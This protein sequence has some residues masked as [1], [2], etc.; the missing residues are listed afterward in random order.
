MVTLMDSA[1]FLGAEESLE[2]SVKAEPAAATAHSSIPD[3]SDWLIVSAAEAAGEDEGA[4]SPQAPPPQAPV[5][6]LV[7]Q[8]VAGSPASSLAAVRALDVDSLDL[9]LPYSPKK[10]SK[11]AASLRGFAVKPVSTFW[12]GFLLFS[13]MDTSNPPIGCMVDDIG[14]RFVAPPSESCVHD[15]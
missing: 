7:A 10:V 2:L 8:S 5:D 14:K 15:V 13:T 11:R 9:G 12:K 3:G 4:P 6:A 1:V